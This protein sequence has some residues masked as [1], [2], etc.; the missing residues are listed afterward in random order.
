MDPVTSLAAKVG[1]AVAKDF[2]KKLSCAGNESFQKAR[3]DLYEE[4]LIDLDRRCEEQ[5]A[6]LAQRIDNLDQQVSERG[7]D[8]SCI[9]IAANYARAADAEAIDQRRGMLAYAE[10]ALIDTTLT[11]AQHS[12]VERLLRE[13]DPDDVLWLNVL[14]KIVGYRLGAKLLR[15]E[16]HVRW[17]VWN[18][19]PASDVL[20]ASACVRVTHVGGGMG[21]VDWE[22][23][24]VT[25]EGKLVLHVLRLYVRATK[26]PIEIPG[27]DT[28]AG[29]KSER[30]AREVLDQ[31]MGLSSDVMRLAANRSAIYD[32]PKSNAREDSPPPPANAKS[33]LR[34][35]GIP[36]Q[37]AEAVAAKAPLHPSTPWVPVGTPVDQ[38]LI[39]APAGDG[40][41]TLQ[42][43]GPHDVL[44]WLADEVEARWV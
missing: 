38:V 23:V 27:R 42:I 6:Y 13:L 30:D 9:R 17:T 33:V 14:D 16:D 1:F 5:F 29:D 32:T 36:R 7:K 10:A 25:R 8:P 43:H 12:R 21:G 4:Y 37:E 41:H 28:R 18:E 24:T 35:F 11:L 31:V 44:R 2:F 26:L 20:A 22:K 3:R 19:S 34:V 40:G 39:D 15:H